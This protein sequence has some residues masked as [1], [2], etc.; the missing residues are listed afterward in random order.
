MKLEDVEKAIN[1][2]RFPPRLLLLGNG[3]A[4][5]LEWDL[6]DG[7]MAKAVLEQRHVRML[8]VYSVRLRNDRRRDELQRGWLTNE[9]AAEQYVA[10]LPKAF[11]PQPKSCSSYRSQINNRV[12]RAAAEASCGAWKPELVIGV[13]NLGARIVCELEIVPYDSHSCATA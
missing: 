6:P 11:A 13:R 2:V 7:S 5:R 10:G 3:G 8:K 9:Q 12:K 1:D 4:A